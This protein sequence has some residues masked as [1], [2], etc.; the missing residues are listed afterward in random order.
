MKPTRLSKV[1]M[2]DNYETRLSGVNADLASR[3]TV[4]RWT[5]WGVSIESSDPMV[6]AKAESIA[7]QFP[8][9][10]IRKGTDYIVVE[11]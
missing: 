4:K 7:E 8:Y 5:S 6:L 11:F 1:R 2:A 10:R 9:T 3:M